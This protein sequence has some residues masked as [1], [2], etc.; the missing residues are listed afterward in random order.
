[1]LDCGGGAVWIRNGVASNYCVK[2]FGLMA[3]LG[4]FETPSSAGLLSPPLVRRPTLLLLHCRCIVA[5]LPAYIIVMMMI[6]MMI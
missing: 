4:L 5:V 1:V 2:T 3:S 6:M